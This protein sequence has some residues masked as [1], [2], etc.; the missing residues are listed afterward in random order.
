MDSMVARS[1][2][3][4]ALAYHTSRDF[5]VTRIVIGNKTNLKST[6]ISSGPWEN[7]TVLT[8]I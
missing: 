3:H 1:E 2:R 5:T 8:L 7:S 6:H 4:L